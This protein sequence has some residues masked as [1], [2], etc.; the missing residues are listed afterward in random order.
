LKQELAQVVAEQKKT[1]AELQTSQNKVKEL[2]DKLKGRGPLLGARH[3][4]WDSI[5]GE[6]TKFRPYLEMMEDKSALANKAL[7]KRLVINEIMSKRSVEVAQNAINM[8][9]T[10]TNE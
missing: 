6:A 2:N 7:H 5:I 4:L 1:N 8:L 10:I 9:N 3:A